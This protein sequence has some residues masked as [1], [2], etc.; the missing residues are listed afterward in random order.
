M[1]RIF[2]DHPEVIDQTF[3]VLDF[4]FPETKATSLMDTDVTEIRPIERRV[5]TVMKV[6]TKDGGSFILVFEAQRKVDADKLASWPYYISF[7]H[8]RHRL[9]V[10]L[11]VIC[12]DHATAK[13]ASA[14]ITMLVEDWPSMRVQPLVVGP[15]NVPVPQGPIDEAGILLGV[16]AAIT[17]A[18]EPGIDGIPN[19]MAAALRDTDASTRS[20]LAMFIQLGVEG[21]PAAQIWRGLM[22]WDIETLRTSEV[23]REI[24]DEHDEQVAAEG[25]AKAKVENILSLLAG[26]DIHVTDVERHRIESCRDLG[27]LDRWFD[28]AISATSTDDLFA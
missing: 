9:P 16:L 6:E 5:D 23:F 1:H 15:H 24:L 26:R 19:L 25:A 8:E 3:R 14:P 20:N 2:R 28:A 12:Q 13:W 18:R 21:L 10:L 7:L 11:L 22:I 17:H 4:K 27:T